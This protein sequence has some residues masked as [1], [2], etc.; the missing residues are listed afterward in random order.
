MNSSSNPLNPVQVNSKLF[1][2]SLLIGQD[3]GL[4]KDIFAWLTTMFTL[5]CY[6]DLWWLPCSVPIQY[7][8]ESIL[9]LSLVPLFLPGLGSID[10]SI[11]SFE[12]L[13]NGCLGNK[14]PRIHKSWAWCVRNPSIWGAEVGVQWFWSHYEFSIPGYLKKMSKNTYYSWKGLSLIPNIRSSWTAHNCLKDP[15]P[16]APT[17]SSGLCGY[18]KLN[19]HTVPRPQM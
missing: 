7:S 3:L 18:L 15:A 17:P 8:A 12:Q 10:R 6:I 13:A 9:C 14:L 2:S 16:K 1:I 4:E 5:T 19:R 11:S